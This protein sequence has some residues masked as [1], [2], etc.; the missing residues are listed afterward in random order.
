MGELLRQ[1]GEMEPGACASI[2][3]TVAVLFVALLRA[4]GLRLAPGIISVVVAILTGVVLGFAA[5]GWQG[6]L[7]GAIAGL[8]ATGG[9]QVIVQ[10]R[11]ARNGG[12]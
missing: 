1:L 8:G 7:L 2:I 4:F 11:K 10:A 5:G 9:H 12:G 3:L 6:A